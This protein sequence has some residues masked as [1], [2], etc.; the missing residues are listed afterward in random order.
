VTFPPGRAKLAIAGFVAGGRA[1]LHAISAADFDVLAG[2]PKPTKQRL[3][4][5]AVGALANRPKK[6]SR[7]TRRTGRR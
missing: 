6:P 7:P 4:R 3:L 5:E 1:A 2:T